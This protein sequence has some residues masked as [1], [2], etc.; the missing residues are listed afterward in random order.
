ML[1]AWFLLIL[2]FIIKITS[3]P[4]CCAPVRFWEVLKAVEG[5]V[6]G[7][8]P[9][10][11]DEWNKVPWAQNNYTMMICVMKFKSK[12]ASNNICKPKQTTPQSDA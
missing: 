5:D 3:V 9:V 7:I 10:M 6:D 4:K 2:I 1:N 12:P 8:T 11:L